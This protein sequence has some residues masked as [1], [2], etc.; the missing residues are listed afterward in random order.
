MWM[1]T[2]FQL[3]KSAFSFHQQA[4]SLTYHVPKYEKIPFFKKSLHIFIKKCNSKVSW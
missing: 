4:D 1:S 2:T 3:Y